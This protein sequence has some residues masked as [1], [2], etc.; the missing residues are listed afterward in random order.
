MSFESRKKAFKRNFIK[1]NGHLF[2]EAC[3]KNYDLSVH[4]IIP[5][6]R[7]ENN[8]QSN[9]ILL[10]TRC[11]SIADNMFFPRVHEVTYCIVDFPTQ[12]EDIIQFIQGISN[13][14]LGPNKGQR[15]FEKRKSYAQEIKYELTGFLYT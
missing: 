14:V 7:E 1:K 5:R 3:N 8:S 4:H 12:K 10:C 2:C 9:Y 11:H 15:R 13:G 6:R